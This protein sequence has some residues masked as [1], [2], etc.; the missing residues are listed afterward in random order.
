MDNGYSCSSD[1]ENFEFMALYSNLG[2]LWHVG[3][4]TAQSSKFL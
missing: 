3:K 4:A 2:N 1:E